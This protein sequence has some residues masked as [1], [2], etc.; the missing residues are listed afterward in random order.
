MNTSERIKNYLENNHTATVNQLSQ[1]LG[2]TRAA[3]HYQICLL[4]EQ[5]SVEVMPDKFQ[6]GAGKPARQY[7]LTNSPAVNL[8]A[9]L[10]ALFIE[11]LTDLSNLYQIE[12][13]LSSVISDGILHSVA[14]NAD[15]AGLSPTIKLNRLID[16]LSMMG[17]KIR[18]QAGI[19]GPLLEIEHENLSSLI[20]DRVL[21]QNTLNKLIRKLTLLITSK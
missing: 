1:K 14:E 19:D 5:G 13:N 6:N 4:Q 12:Y 21:V 18:W 17:I 10:I 8:S 3:I 2:L 16:K 20:T 9:T 15:I 7:K 11:A